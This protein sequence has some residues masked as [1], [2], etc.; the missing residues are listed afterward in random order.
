M[1]G[2]KLRQPYRGLMVIGLPGDLPDAI[3][4]D[5]SDLR[6]GQ[7]IR[8]SSLPVEGITYLDPNDAVILAVKMARGAV[9]E[10]EEE[11]EEGEE[12]AEGGESSEESND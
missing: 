9:E 1:N 11:E 5:I 2:G 12:G 7:S 6:I 3:T 10:E 8:I 4:V